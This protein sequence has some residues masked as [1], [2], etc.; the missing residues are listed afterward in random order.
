MGPHLFNETEEF[1]MLV[2]LTFVKRM[3]IGGVLYRK[4]RVYEVDEDW[5]IS[6]CAI[7]ERDLPCF[8]MANE[9][10]V[11]KATAVIDLSSGAEGNEAE[12]ERTEAEIAAEVQSKAPKGGN[13]IDKSAA[14][15]K[16][17]TGVV[18]K[19]LSAESQ[20]DQEQV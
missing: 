20:K 19:K 8:R 13:V 18:I 9:S 16:K 4:N 3:N 10:D 17:K 15:A 5:G 6:L 14:T 12:D 1:T 11:D 7:T 2:T